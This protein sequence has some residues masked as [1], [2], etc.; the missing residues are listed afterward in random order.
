MLRD[1][2]ARFVGSWVSA[3]GYRLRI[4]KVRNDRA[5][6]DFLDP[7]G[8]PVERAYM[9]CAPSIG[10]TAHYDDYH[11]N[12][13]VDLWEQGKGFTLHL[14][15]EY[16]YALDA[17]QR[18]ALLPAIS[19]NERDHFLDSFYSLFGPLDHFVRR[20]AGTRGYGQQ[21]PAASAR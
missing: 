14:E 7:R 13:E 18:E 9:G 20:K 6:V 10:M 12:V 21:P 17:E 8:A 5:S 16:G 3:S 2:I 4:R 11:E 1:G 15:H 19:R